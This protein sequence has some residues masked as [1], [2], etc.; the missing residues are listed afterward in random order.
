MKFRTLLSFLEAVATPP[1]R[2]RQIR[3][4]KPGLGV[5]Q[6]ESRTLMAAGLVAAYNFDQGNGN[7]LADTS[8]NNNNGTITG[9]SWV[10][11]GK[12]GGAL[13]FSGATNSYVT[14]PNAAS[15][16][17]TSSMTLEAWVDPT[18][19]DRADQ[20]WSAAIAKEHR[21]SINDI[22]YALYAANGYGTGP[23]AHILTRGT[24]VGAESTRGIA[25]EP[26]DL[27]G[28]DLRRRHHKGICQRQPD[29]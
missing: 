17:L 26:V 25:L 13:S 15:L 4:Y 18:T 29:G 27:S 5:E 11:N 10:T 9:A 20:G 12:F 2:N 1:K 8:G 14:V 7:V 22:S 16:Q 19:L 28:G 23:G 21:N 6:L 24:D 3:P